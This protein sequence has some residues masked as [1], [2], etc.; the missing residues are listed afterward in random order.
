M[1]WLGVE[2]DRIANRHNDQ[3]IS[4]ARSRVQV[5]VIPTNEEAMIARHTLALL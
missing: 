5:F 3:L 2:L 1:E 4:T